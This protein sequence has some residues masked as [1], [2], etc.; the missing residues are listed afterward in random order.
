MD[1][2]GRIR[3]VEV[4]MAVVCC[5]RMKMLDEE[6]H[7]EEKVRP[8]QA[9]FTYMAISLNQTHDCLTFTCLLQ[10]VGSCR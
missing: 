9:A 3:D 10:K 6:L 7:A 1:L 8:T 5:L 4:P 2:V